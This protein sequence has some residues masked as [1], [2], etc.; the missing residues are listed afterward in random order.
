MK[1]PCSGA[2]ADPDR[3]FSAP[4][5]RHGP[6][7]VFCGKTTG[8]IR[9]M[10]RSPARAV[11]GAADRRAAPEPA[12]TKAVVEKSV[13]IG[14]SAGWTAIGAIAAEKGRRDGAGQGRRDYLLGDERD[15]E[16]ARW[17]WCGNR[18]RRSAEVGTN[19]D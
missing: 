15:K 5:R 3:Q 2:L 17:P 8:C 10:Q 14:G 19:V 12:H 16:V 18:G 4:A 1:A 9:Q 11:P 13:I 6:H 7:P